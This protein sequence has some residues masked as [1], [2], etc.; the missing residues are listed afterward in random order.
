[1]NQMDCNLISSV[2]VEAFL[3]MGRGIARFC[4]TILKQ[5][6]ICKTGKY[7]PNLLFILKADPR[8]NFLIIIQGGGDFC[9]LCAPF[10]T[11]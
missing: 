1:M 7:F 4:T 3:A 5:R 8:E 2:F 6:R 11:F 9:A 10:R